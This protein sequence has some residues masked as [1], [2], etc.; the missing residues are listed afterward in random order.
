MEGTIGSDAG[1]FIRD[2]IKSVASQGEIVRKHMALRRHAR[3]SRW[4]VS[5]GC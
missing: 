3:T 5:S 2:G 1:A 4:N